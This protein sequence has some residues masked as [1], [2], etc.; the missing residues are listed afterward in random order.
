MLFRSDMLK[1]IEEALQDASYRD[2]RGIY[3]LCMGA[4]LTEEKEEI[5]HE[6]KN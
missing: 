2:V 1:E 6:R 4:G 3:M 5:E